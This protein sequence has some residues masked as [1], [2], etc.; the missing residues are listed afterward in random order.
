VPRTSSRPPANPVVTLA[1]FGQGE[2]SA[3]N[4]DALLNDLLD[5]FGEDADIVFEFPIDPDATTA[6]IKEVLEWASP[7]NPQEGVDSLPY[8][9]FEVAEPKTKGLREIEAD[10]DEVRKFSEFTELADVLTKAGQGNNEA[11]LLFLWDDSEPALDQQVLWACLDAGVAC[12]DLTNGLEDIEGSDGATAAAAPDPTQVAI[13]DDFEKWAIRRMRKWVSDNGF[14]T[15]E[16]V[17]KFTKDDCLEAVGI[18][19][20]D[21]PAET[22]KPAGRGRR[23]AAAA[24]PEAAAPARGRGRG[25]AAAQEAAAEPTEPDGGTIEDEAVQLFVDAL[26]DLGVDQ[27]EADAVG[28]LVESLADIIINRIADRVE[29]EPEG[30]AVRKEISP[31]RPPGKPRNDG[32]TPTRRR[33]ASR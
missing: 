29:R 32:A 23:G 33:T 4:I 14:A 3:E 9:V 11:R 13:P 16:D 28:Q 24:E 22:P 18:G 8:R 10:A 17:A 15:K 2:T 30:S 12:L 6:T 21:T 19:G 1:V 25:R 26:V 31:P 20:T 5:G 7:A 27:T